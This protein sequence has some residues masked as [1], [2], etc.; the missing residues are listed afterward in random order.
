M[1][2]LL[3]RELINIKDWQ[4]IQD[5]LSEVLELSLRTFS[6]DGEAMTKTSRPNHLCAVIFPHASKDADVLHVCMAESKIKSISGID[7]ETKIICPFGLNAFIIPI[8]AVADE[9]V[10]YLAL[11]P[12]MLAK[13][14]DASAYSKEA[15][16]F[17]IDLEQLMDTLLDMPVFTYNRLNEVIKLM[18]EV[19]SHI[20]Q[21]GYHKK[22][23][24][25][26]K[27]EVMQLDPGF[28]RYYED[29]IL[30][31]LLN[32]CTLAL[33]ADSGSVMTLNESTNMLHI[34]V[35]SKLD[36]EIVNNTN[37][38]MGEG[39]AGLAAA[40]SKPIILPQDKDNKAIS[41]KMK[42]K[43]ITS[44]MIVPFSKPN[45]ESAYGVINLNI[46]RKNIN[47]SDRDIA[48]V[49]ELVNLASI[50]LTPLKKST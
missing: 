8:M 42:R 11:G 46:M 12:V 14:G 49:K 28:S 1:T 13:R 30:N 44:S 43:D 48:L 10:A 9:I 17:G 19:F 2:K 6:F 26:I 23:L 38:K 40:T 25:E 16:R 34:K 37:V 45:S 24:G 35:S 15:S 22:R 5:S 21:A 3:F 4:A 41:G 20:A 29:K 27:P 39:I 50:A 32:S 36:K 18:T 47:F 7:K 31:S 33:N